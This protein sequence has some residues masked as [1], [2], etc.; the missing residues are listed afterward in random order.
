MVLEVVYVF[1]LFYCIFVGEISCWFCI[2]ELGFASIV[3]NCLF[4]F[5]LL[6]W[7]FFGGRG[8]IFGFSV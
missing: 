8:V 3:W 6:D 2:W 4:S 1:L 5:F 7:G